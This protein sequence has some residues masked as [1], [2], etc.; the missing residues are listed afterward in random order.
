MILGPSK[1]LQVHQ[2]LCEWH[3]SAFTSNQLM[4]HKTEDRNGAYGTLMALQGQAGKTEF[5]PLLPAL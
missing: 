4:F 3:P 1:N 2:V 5:K